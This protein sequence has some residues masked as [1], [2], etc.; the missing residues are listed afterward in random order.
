M[1]D[2]VL[3]SFI[4][5]MCRIVTEKTAFKC[6]GQTPAYIHETIW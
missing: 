5:R 6:N 3:E 4:M 2:K 1:D